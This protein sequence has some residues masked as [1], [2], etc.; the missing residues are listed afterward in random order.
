MSG[1]F[2]DRPTNRDMVKT[3]ESNPLWGGRPDEEDV[4]KEAEDIGIFDSDA[5]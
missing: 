2:S 3:P 1:L 5:E 4:L